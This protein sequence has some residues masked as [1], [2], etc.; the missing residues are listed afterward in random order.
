MVRDLKR[1]YHRVVIGYIEAFEEKSDML[2]DFWVGDRF[3]GV[4]V[5]GDYTIDFN[6][7]RLIVDLDLDIDLF[8]E[9][10]DYSLA[11]AFEQ[12]GHTN[13]DVWLKIKGRL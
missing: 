12:G 5:F 4:A 2:F 7:I 3:G 6:N 9:W 11:Q 13:F 1:E 10:W 8:Y